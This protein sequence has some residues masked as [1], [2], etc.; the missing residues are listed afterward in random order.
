MAS[1]CGAIAWPTTFYA[2]LRQGVSNG[3]ELTAE[4]APAGAF[5]LFGHA[6]LSRAAA[7]A[8]RRRAGG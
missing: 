1:S 5:G 2:P 6:A 8:S 4:W 3:A 7:G